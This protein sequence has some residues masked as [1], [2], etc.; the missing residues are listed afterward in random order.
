MKYTNMSDPVESSTANPSHPATVADKSH[1]AA[2][3]PEAPAIREFDD[4]AKRDLIASIKKSLEREFPLEH[5]LPITSQAEDLHTAIQIIPD[6]SAPAA[7]ISEAPIIREFDDDDP[8][9]ELI[10]SIKKR[11]ENEFPLEH[12]LPSTTEAEDLFP[13]IEEMCMSGQQDFTTSSKHIV[14]DSSPEIA[15][16]PLTNPDRSQPATDIPEAPTIRDFDAKSKLIASIKKRLEDEFPLEHI[17][18]STTGAEDLLDAI[19]KICK[20]GEQDITTFSKHIVGVDKLLIETR[21]SPWDFISL[22]IDRRNS[23]TPGDGE[24]FA[25]EM[26]MLVDHFITTVVTEMVQS[27]KG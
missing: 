4:E 9:R 1:P 12:I 16:H 8:K 3:I 21:C 18:P 20:S 10:A 7:V 6:R 26:G 23:A 5:I 11:L 14:G 15:S 17:L 24:M 22:L 2:C 19:E 27:S 13:A 25:A